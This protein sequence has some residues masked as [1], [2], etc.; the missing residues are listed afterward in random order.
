MRLPLTYRPPGIRAARMRR[1]EPSTV[2]GVMAVTYALADQLR[3][4]R[5]A[6]TAVSY[7]EPEADW[8]SGFALFASPP[9]GSAPPTSC[10]SNARSTN[11][12]S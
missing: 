1:P 7:L 6:I 2:L 3:R 9:A 4:R 10:A 11:G 12:P 5:P 8:D